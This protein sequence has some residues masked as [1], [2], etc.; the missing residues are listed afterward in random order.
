[1]SAKTVSALRTEND[2]QY[3][4]F[5]GLIRERIK[6]AQPPFFTTDADPADLWIDYLGNIPCADRQ[7]YTCR[8]CRKFIE[9]YG[10]LATIDERGRVAPVFWLVND[11]HDFMGKMPA[12]FTDSVRDMYERVVTAR[13]AGVFL[14]SETTWGTPVT[15]MW[16][17]L[18]GNN[19]AIFSH[20]TLTAE[21]MMAEKREDFKTLETGLQEYSLPVLEQAVR[22]LEAD[23][24]DRSEKTLGVARWLLDL[25]QRLAANG[26]VKKPINQN[27]IWRAVAT[28]PPGFCHVRST[29]ISTLLA[30]I[31]SGMSFDAISRRWAQKMHP[32]QYQRPT[33]LSEGQLRA[34]N[35]QVE[36]MKSAG[37]LARRFARIEDI[38]P[39]G[40][41]WKP[42]A[43]ME[44]ANRQVVGA[45]DHLRQRVNPLVAVIALPAQTITWEKF[46]REILPDALEIDFQVPAHGSFYGMVTAANADAPPILQWDGLEGVQRFA[47][48]AGFDGAPLVGSVTIRS[49]PSRNPVSWYF[50][51]GGSDARDWSLIPWSWVKVRLICRCPPHWQ[52]PEKF[53]HHTQMA[54]FVLDG[55]RDAMTSSG[56]GGLFPECLRS[57]YHG[58][59]HALEAHAKNAVVA[60]KEEGDANGYALQKGQTYQCFLR[61]RTK[62]GAAQ[63]RLDR[64]D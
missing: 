36:K 11:R 56:G 28:A 44:E 60:G 35:A 40:V 53:T 26:H 17:H 5:E 54:M 61:V 27:L 24:L 63:Y 1:M 45:F 23:A 6:N 38:L 13:V 52:Q 33:T 4:A 48:K 32:L 62:A 12:F 49:A 10:G 18:H 7:H 47:V 14:S 41:I 9:R 43:I 19:P 20:P 55:A 42:R 58:I 34:A 39:Q 50:Y 59:R 57:E 16:T 3:D 64:W 25:Q 46:S 8:T 31:A 15:G 21:Q 30:D 37:A 51:N 22:V 29:M 2:H